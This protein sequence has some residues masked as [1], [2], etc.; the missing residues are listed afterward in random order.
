[1]TC[2]DDDVGVLDLDQKEAIVMSVQCQDGVKSIS[3]PDIQTL[4]LTSQ[5]HIFIF[6]HF[7]RGFSFWGLLR[8]GIAVAIEFY[9]VRLNN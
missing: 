8:S 5:S 4:H 7:H 9:H 3:P 6:I 1:M 2:C